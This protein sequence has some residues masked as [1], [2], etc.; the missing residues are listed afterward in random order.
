MKIAILSKSRLVVHK[1]LPTEDSPL[2]SRADT[3][4]ALLARL[5][6]GDPRISEF[7]FRLDI[8]T[9]LQLQSHVQALE[10]G[11]FT[12]YNIKGRNKRGDVI[13]QTTQGDWMHV[14]SG[15]SP[16]HGTLGTICEVRSK[17]YLKCERKEARGCMEASSKIHRKL[18]SRYEEFKSLC[19]YNNRVD[20]S[21]AGMIRNF[22][23]EALERIAVNVPALKQTFAVEI[24]IHGIDCETLDERTAQFTIEKVAQAI[25]NRQDVRADTVEQNRLWYT[26]YFKNLRGRFLRLQFSFY[27]VVFSNTN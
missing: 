15:L 27:S 17:K 13:L 20:V 23:S 2:Y 26:V 21:D 1:E 22:L 9:P 10:A 3:L 19:V 4:Q 8:S 25:A 12:P 5:P 18:P 6:F 7:L 24:S 16:Q 11:C 14:I